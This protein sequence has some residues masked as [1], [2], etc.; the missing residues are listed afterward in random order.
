MTV[1]LSRAQLAELARLLA[2]TAPE[3]VDCEVFHRHLAALVERHGAAVDT[4]ELLRSLRQHIEVCPECREEFE[5]L[6][7]AMERRD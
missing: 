5:A 4:P 2:S 1:E 6:L 7:R 3:E